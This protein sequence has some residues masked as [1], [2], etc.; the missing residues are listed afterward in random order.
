MKRINTIIIVAITICL[1]GC[2]TKSLHPFYKKEDVIQK[3][4]LLG[5]WTD[6]EKSTWSITRDTISKK[7][8]D[9]KKSLSKYYIFKQTEKDGKTADFKVHLFKLNNQLFMDFVLDEIHSN[10]TE[11]SAYHL[12]PTHTVAKLDI[13]N[14]KN[15]KIKWY[16]EGSLG[17]LLKERKIRIK[18]EV[19]S[20]DSY[21]LTAETDELQKF[22]IKYDNYIEEVAKNKKEDDV[23]AILKFSKSDEK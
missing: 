11:M 12:V 9:P 10:L 21:L 7:F 4:L 23:Y 15:F 16:F 13:D 14:D 20:K 6:N 17:D 3:D 19:V 1:S 8:L 5:T 2:L 22:L 18:H